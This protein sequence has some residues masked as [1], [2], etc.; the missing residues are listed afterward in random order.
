MTWLFAAACVAVSVPAFW[1]PSLRETF[2]GVGSP[3]SAWQRIWLPFQHGFPGMPGP[4]HLAFNLLLL[5]TVGVEAERLLGSLRFA[6]LSIA[7]A[8]TYALAHALP[9]VDGHGASGVIW[10]YGPVLFFGLRHAVRSGQTGAPRAARARG[11]LW[12]LWGAVTLFMTVIPYAGGYRG[13]PLRP[14]L[15]GNWFHLVA[16]LTGFPLAY[17]WRRRIAAR[18]DLH[19]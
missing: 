10:A 14:L 18:W 8:G 5:L 15:L 17:A 9:W 7:A 2:G 11:W 12:L 4:V 16:T 19:R 3:A 1:D 13:S 6:A